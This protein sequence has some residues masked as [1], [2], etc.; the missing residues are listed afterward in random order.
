MAAYNR[1]VRFSRRTFDTLGVSD[2][3]KRHDV[4]G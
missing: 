3:L 4:A 2:A 1:E